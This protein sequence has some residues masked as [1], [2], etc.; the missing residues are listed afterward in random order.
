MK[1]SADSRSWLSIIRVNLRTC[2]AAG[3]FPCI[4]PQRCAVQ[5]YGSSAR[6]RRGPG[7]DDWPGRWCTTSAGESGMS[8]TA[9]YVDDGRGLLFRGEGA[10]TCEQ[11]IAAKL[12]LL[13]D[14]AR[15]RRV[16]HA[17]VVF[18]RVTD[19]PLTAEDIRRIC[20]APTGNSHGSRLTSS[21]PLPQPRTCRSALRACGRCSPRTSAGRRR[22]SAAG[23][24]PTCGCR[25]GSRCSP[26]SLAEFAG[27]DDLA[28]IHATRA[29]RAHGGPG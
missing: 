13:S 20:S 23:R 1:S 29:G 26:R 17:T 18:E 16:S 7:E 14:P 28:A 6:T 3:G 12:G 5:P 4:L 19:V 25:R 9:E 27:P 24:R 10:L 8:F 15:L 21:S 11:I 22:C 2:G